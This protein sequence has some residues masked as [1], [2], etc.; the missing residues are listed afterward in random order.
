[1]NKSNNKNNKKKSGRGRPPAIISF[2]KRGIFTVKT[3]NQ[4]YPQYTKV[5]IGKL[6]KRAVENKQITMVDKK[7][8]AGNGKGQPERFYRFGK[9][10]NVKISFVPKTPKK[11]Y[12]PKAKT[13]DIKIKV[14]EQ[15]IL[16]QEQI[17]IE[18]E[19][20]YNDSFA[21]AVLEELVSCGG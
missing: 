2:P 4:K 3:L 13:Q 5:T 10:K 9:I 8:V 7:I 21:P 19:D 1:M 20:S 15:P 16:K 14:S 17:F 11:V 6:V 18:K 12:K